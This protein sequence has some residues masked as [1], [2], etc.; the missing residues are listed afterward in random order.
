MIDMTSSQA[1]V[2]GVGVALIIVIAHAVAASVWREKIL[3]RRRTPEE[4]YRRNVND[5]RQVQSDLSRHSDRVRARQ[6]N[7]PDSGA[8]GVGGETIDPLQRLTY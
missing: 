1:V 2:V 6:S 7:P 5:V 4:R 3:D 8:S